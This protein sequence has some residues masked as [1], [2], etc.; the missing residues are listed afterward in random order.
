M[1][2][3]VGDAPLIL[4]P[5]GRLTRAVACVQC[6][7]KLSG[8]RADEYCPSCGA[9]VFATA[10]RHMDRIDAE[11]RV[12]IDAACGSCGYNL[13]SQPVMGVCPECAANVRTTVLVAELSDYDFDWLSTIFSGSRLIVIGVILTILVSIGFGVGA[14]L[15]FGGGGAPTNLTSFTL[16]SAFIGVVV[17]AVSWFGIYRFTAPNPALY[18][19]ETAR[20]PRPLARQALAVTIVIALIS[21]PLSPFTNPAIGASDTLILLGGLLSVVG[22]LVWF[23]MVWLVTRCAH[24]ILAAV[25]APGMARFATAMARFTLAILIISPITTIITVLMSLGSAAGAG[26]GAA[27]AGGLVAVGV[28]GSILGCVSTMWGLAL[29]VFV[30]RVHLALK[31]PFNEAQAQRDPVAEARP[32][33]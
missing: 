18:G 10:A 1:S 19:V 29:L 27:P 3:S 32:A 12:R 33:L 14:A 15:F 21:V 13:R 2:T 7:T 9:P 11:G 6:N 22:S 17:A 16:F 8:L 20:S 5:D 25:P 23:G 26:P 28:I 31:K 24:Q 4:D 30:G